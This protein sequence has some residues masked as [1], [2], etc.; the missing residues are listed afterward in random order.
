MTKSQNKGKKRKRKKIK[1]KEKQAYGA[2][3]PLYNRSKIY[4]SLT[5]RL[6]NIKA[7]KR[8][9]KLSQPVTIE[10]VHRHLFREVVNEKERN[11]SDLDLKHMIVHHYHANQNVCVCDLKKKKTQH[12]NKHKNKPHLGLKIQS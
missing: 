5:V 3:A 8:G 9:K 10:Q 7:R 12:K 1:L 6:A 2:V 4:A 11:C